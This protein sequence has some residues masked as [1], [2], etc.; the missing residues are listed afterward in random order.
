MKGHIWLPGKKAPLVEVE[1]EKTKRIHHSG[2]EGARLHFGYK[3]N[4]KENLALYKD[5]DIVLE[6]SGQKFPVRILSL[7]VQPDGF[8]GIMSVRGPFVDA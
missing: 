6:V 2:A 5:R 7:S 8:T 4:T 1:W 3:G